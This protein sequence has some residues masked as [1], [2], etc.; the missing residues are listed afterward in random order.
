MVEDFNHRLGVDDVAGNHGPDFTRGNALWQPSRS[1]SHPAP[2][3]AYSRRC[4]AH[5]AVAGDNTTAA[6]FIRVALSFRPK[7]ERS[8]MAMEYT[9][10][11]GSRGVVGRF[12]PVSS[13]SQEHFSSSQRTYAAMKPVI[14]LLL[15]LYFTGAAIFIGGEIN[16][17]IE[18]AAADAGNP[19]VRRP[20]EPR[21]GG[22]AW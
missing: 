16:S 4:L 14:A 5:H 10:S 13:I 8:Q 6:L 9:G 11:G 12:N 3:L 18:K 2:W 7:P 20:G 19:D 1:G 17:E 15:W 21:S 22:S